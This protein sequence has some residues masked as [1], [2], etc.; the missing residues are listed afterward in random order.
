MRLSKF[1]GYNHSQE[2]CDHVVNMCSLD[3]MK[4]IERERS[5]DY[6]G[7]KWKNSQERLIGDGM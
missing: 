5:T 7:V 3:N 2:F 4:K 6:Y 1:L